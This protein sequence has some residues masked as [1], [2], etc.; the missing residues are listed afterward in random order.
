MSKQST[1]GD[2]LIHGSKSSQRN[3]VI[4]SRIIKQ[5][6]AEELT[7]AFYSM[8]SS[9]FDLLPLL[10]TETSELPSFNLK[11]NLQQPTTYLSLEAAAK[12]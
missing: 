1:V 9:S 4:M 10:V 11:T 12:R 2:G 5:L 6:A 8:I 7:P 3:V